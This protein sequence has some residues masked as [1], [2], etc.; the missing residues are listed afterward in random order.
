MN[1]LLIFDTGRLVPSFDFYG[2]LHKPL[3]KSGKKNW[4]GDREEK[5]GDVLSVVKSSQGQSRL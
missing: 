1:N 3:K 5:E 4:H 2:G